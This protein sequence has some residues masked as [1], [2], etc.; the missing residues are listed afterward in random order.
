MKLIFSHLLTR[1]KL[2]NNHSQNLKSLL[3][4]QYNVSSL[5][6]FQN[7]WTKISWVIR[8][9]QKLYKIFQVIL[10]QSTRKWFRF[11]HWNDCSRDVVTY[12]TLEVIIHEWYLTYQKDRVISAGE[13]LHIEFINNCSLHKQLSSHLSHFT[14]F[15]LKLIACTLSHNHK[16]QWERLWKSY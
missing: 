13:K 12:K 5:T 14:Y 8:R 2:L 16:V 7:S 9:D 4:T 6:W 11:C 1:N 3:T 15:C 10:R